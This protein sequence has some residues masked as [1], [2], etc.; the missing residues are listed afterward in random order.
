MSQRR[1]LGPVINL[2]YNDQGLN[3]AA[4]ALRAGMCGVCVVGQY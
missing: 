3:Q 1:Y 2:T 4:K